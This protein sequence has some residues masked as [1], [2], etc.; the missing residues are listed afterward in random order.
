MRVYELARKLEMESQDLI[1]LLQDE[2]DLEVDNHMV[3]IDDDVVELVKEY[4]EEEETEEP[5][6]T[7]AK[8]EKTED[9]DELEVGAEE[10]TADSVATDAFAEPVDEAAEDILVVRGEVTTQELARMLDISTSEIIKK[11]IT[12]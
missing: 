9:E 12:Q 4:L 7:D 10:K 8:E 1:E 3:G 11:L 2:F 5:E 6:K